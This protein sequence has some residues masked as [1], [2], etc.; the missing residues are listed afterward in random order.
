MSEDL[1]DPREPGDGRGRAHR[2]RLAALELGGARGAGREAEGGA[3]PRR[4]PRRAVA[5]LRSADALAPVRHGAHGRRIRR[6]ACVDTFCRAHDHPNLFVVDASF[7]PTSAAV[8]PALTIAAQAL[9]VG[10]PHQSERIWRHETRRARHRRSAGHRPRHRLGA[11]RRGLCGG[12]G[13]AQRPRTD[14]VREA[15]G[16]L[17]RGR[18]LLSPRPA[19]G[20]GSAGAAR[21]DRGGARAGDVARLQ[22]RRAGEGARRHAR[23]RARQLRLRARRQPARRLLP[24]AGD[25][26]AHAGAAA[27]ALPLDRLR[28]LGQRGD[29]LDRTRRILHLQ[30]R[31]GDDGGALRGAAGAARHR[32]LRASA[33]HHRDRHDRRGEGQIHRAHRGRPGAGRALGA[34]GRHRRGGR[35]RWCAATWPSPPAR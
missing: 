12:A 11:G 19:G 17:G 22:R 20:G 5:A 8:N 24:G 26:A 28:H 7:L 34:A 29:G 18:P 13:V 14:A 27:G 2:A 33:R 31:R 10:R 9:R 35:C 32:R 21:P 23:P 1:P 16:A 15:L 6:R 25:G 30:G 3:A 4:L